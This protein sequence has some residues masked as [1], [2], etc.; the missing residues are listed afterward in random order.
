MKDTHVRTIATGMKK[1][2]LQIL[3]DLKTFNS[4]CEQKSMALNSV[5]EVPKLY[6][7]RQE[8]F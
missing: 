8:V 4:S 2:H 5:A 1:E 7:W 6:D 3:S